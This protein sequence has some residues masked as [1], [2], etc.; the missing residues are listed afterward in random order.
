MSSLH[1]L[2][3]IFEDN[4]KLEKPLPPEFSA[5]ME[6]EEYKNLYLRKAGAFMLEWGQ[7]HHTKDLSMRLDEVPRMRRTEFVNH[8]RAFAHDVT[9]K[10][11]ALCAA[12]LIWLYVYNCQQ[13]T[14]YREI[15][16]AELDYLEAVLAQ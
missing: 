16:E 15:V 12:R 5:I 2:V 7:K 14:A 11:E 10:A 1:S 3:S 13:L 6:S 8:L 9:T 4:N